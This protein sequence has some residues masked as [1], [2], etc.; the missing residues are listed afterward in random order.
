VRRCADPIVKL[1]LTRFKKSAADIVR[2]STIGHA[3][4]INVFLIFLSDKDRGNAAW[5]KALL[6]LAKWRIDKVSIRPL[7][8]LLHV[9]NWPFALKMAFC[10][11]LAMAA[12]IGLG[13]NGI[14]VTAEQAALIDA[15]VQHDLSTAVGLTDSATRLQQI[16]SSLYRLSTLQ[17]SKTTDLSVTQEIGRLVT[18]TASLADDLAAQGGN[19]GMAAE[20]DD[21]LQ[22]VAKIRVYGEAI[23]VFGSMLEIDF[24]SAVEFFRPFD[25]NATKVLE[26]IGDIADRAVTDAKS[27]AEVSVHLAKTIRL[28]LMAVSVAGSLLLFG[29]AALLTRATVRS[30]NQI[31]TATEKVAQGHAAVDIAVL[32]R[33]D[34][35][36]TIVQSLAIFQSNVR[37]LA[38]LAH[39]DPLTG[40]PNRALFNDRVQQALKLLDRSIGFAVLCLDLDRF[41][42]VNDTLGHPVGDVL[43][44]RVAERL[45]ACVRD[46]DTVARLGGDEFAIILLNLNEPSELD[47]LA[48]RIIETVKSSYE[49]DGH[50]IH[51][52]TS[53]GMALAP[54]DGAISDELLKKADTAL[55]E[56][57]SNGGGSSCFYEDAMNV[58]LQS[59][60]Q[61]EAGLRRALEEDEF[62]LYYQPLVDAQSH[63]VCSCEALVRWNHPE[64]GLIFPDAFI[65]I[66]EASGL[67]G[68]IG[69]W[70]LG[71]ACRDAAS[72]DSDIKIAVNL[73]PSQFKDKN[74]VSYIQAALAASGLP[75]SRL[76]LEITES[77]LLNDSNIILAILLEIKALGVQISMDD[78]GTG[79]SSLSYLRSFPFD[80]V[81]IDRSFIKD[82]PNDKNAMAIIRAIVGLGETFGMTVTAEGVETNEQA[83]LLALE[84][85]THLQGYLFSRAVPAGDI[86]TL[87][88]RFSGAPAAAGA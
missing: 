73:S 44:Q 80:K 67:I 14:L 84:D 19:T 88:E 2:I 31:A 76:E 68:A 40:L 32:A 23:D 15:V 85:C 49:I 52:G 33:D 4:S 46:G 83:V 77:V 48:S 45:R 10:P 9:S 86:P 43:L 27:R 11:A 64:R 63:R 55:Y 22:V 81:K 82:L 79:Y 61:I 50:L 72:W 25:K 38:F 12:L 70:V 69:Q 7:T 29:V 18:Q 56:A 54:A 74:L 26:M 13:L 57:K 8:K 65:P 17:A 24:P 28:S 41:K 62:V 35:L 21:I 66:A 5:E 51:I 60:R 36:G 47:V 58:A 6:R 59:R 3:D 78:F 34:E 71:R 30:V 37:Q 1:K 16:N 75:A 53:I 87:I 42:F 39:H 20:R